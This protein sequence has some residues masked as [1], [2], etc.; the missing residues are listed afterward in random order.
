MNGKL[1]K[2]LRG[3]VQSAGLDP[4]ERRYQA[5]QNLNG[6]LTVRL[7]PT[8]GRKIYQRTKS[9]VLAANRGLTAKP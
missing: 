7:D 2:A 5:R 4:T 8:C 9:I 1:A 3:S 6:T